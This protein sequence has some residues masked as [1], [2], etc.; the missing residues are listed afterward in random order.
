MAERVPLAGL[1]VA[2]VDDAV[3]VAWSGAQPV[4][5]G[6]WLGRV[7]SWARHFAAQAD[8]DV[9][10]HL[11]DAVEFSAALF[12]AWHAAKTVWLP[13]DVLPATIVHLRTQVGQIVLDAAAVEDADASFAFEALDEERTRLR[14]FTSGSSGEPVAVEKMLRQLDREVDALQA[15]FGARLDGALVQG[16]VSHQHIYGLLFRVLWP[17][18][19]RRAFAAQRLVFPEQIAALPAR[20]QAL[21]ASPAHLKRLPAGLDWTGW[22]GGLRTVFSSG[23]PLSADAALDVH[24]LWGS[25]P[26]E[27]FGS[28]ETGGIAE[29]TAGS[30][31][32]AWRALPKVDWCIVDEQ[33]QVRSPHLPDASWHATADRAAAAG[34]GFELLGR[35][36]RIVK[37][38]ERRV[39]LDAIEGRLADSPLVDDARIVPLPGARTLLAAAVVPSAAGTALLDTEGKLALQAQLRAW[40][41]DHVEAVALPKRWRFVAQLPSDARGKSSQRA[42]VELFRASMPMPRW[43]QR[44]ARSAIV[45]LDVESE[46]AVFDGHFPQT[47]VLPGVA[48]LDWALRLGRDAFAIDAPCRRMDALKFHHIVQP[49]VRLT[50]QLDWHPAQ[51]LLAFVY[52]S[53]QTTHASGRLRFHDGDADAGAGAP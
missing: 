49:G 37:L 9:A 16:T 23:G 43:Q 3:I 45:V 14:L 2:G 11:D 8:V 53:S 38:E 36:D 33:L 20:P 34:D 5:R 28:T 13:G 4:T 18:S 17:L 46:L 47:A 50:L 29:R 10:L 1:L 40:L 26:V 24:R 22:A 51:A 27:V 52:S 48:M 7:R 39:S 42:L 31:S 35:V 19:A 32:R 6:D 44:D 25:W 12:G 41:V 21:I 15:R 30:A